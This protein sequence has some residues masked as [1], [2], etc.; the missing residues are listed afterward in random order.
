MGVKIVTGLARFSY[1]NVWKPKEDEH[2]NK[3]YSVALLFPK[4]NKNALKAIQ[5][6]IEEA[7]EEGIETGTFGKKNPGSW[8]KKNTKLTSFK[9]CLRDG[10]DKEDNEEYD[11]MMY[12]NAS[13]KEQ[14]LIGDADRQEIVDEDDFYSGCW[15]R[16]SIVIF[17]YN[18]D[19]NI[20]IGAYLQSVQ[21]LRDGEKLAG[22]AS[23]EE[24]FADDIQDDEFDIIDEYGGEPESLDDDED[25]D[26][27]DIL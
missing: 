27:D 25:L 12:L 15:G 1:A 16:A 22:R 3:K 13:A 18:N 21:K 8:K 11:G 14:P 23:L 2:G 19:S 20:G 24:A 5:E 6:A 26:A 7:I 9:W 10:D 4:K 17:P